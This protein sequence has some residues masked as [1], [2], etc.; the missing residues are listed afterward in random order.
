MSDDIFITGQWD[1]YIELFSIS[2]HQFKSTFQTQDKKNI[3]EICLIESS[4]D[5]YTFAFGDFD[6][7][8]IIGKIIMR[9][10]FEYEFQE[11]KIK[12]IEDV[13]CHSMML[14][15]QNVIAAFVRN[16]DDEYQLKIL[17]IKSRQELHTID[18]NESTYIYPAL[19][20]DY[21]QYPFAFIKDQN[22]ISLINT[23]NY[24]ITTII[25][26]YCS[27]SEQQ[28]IQYRDQDNKYKLID[29]QMYETDEDS[30]EYLNEIRETEISML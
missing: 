28:L 30:Y 15:K 5:E 24:Q 2:N 14:I 25:Q 26:C 19:A 29:I 9:N 3:I 16:Q 10:Q 7:G 6:L 11:D 18:L 4:K 12:L 21:I 22:N 13:S 1:G 23:N 27:F 20:Y 17:D 8:I